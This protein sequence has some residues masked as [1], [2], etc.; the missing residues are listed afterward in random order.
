MGGGQYFDPRKRDWYVVAA[1]GPK[2]IILVLDR[3][4]ITS[5]RLNVLSGSGDTRLRAI[6]DAAKGVLST[7]SR[8]DF[9]S[10]VAFGDDVSVLSPKETTERATNETIF[11]L[12]E[13]IDSLTAQ[14]RA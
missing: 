6:K 1:T 14:G 5:A 10:V 13:R 7:L 11:D 9:V 2:D 8:N 4:S 3:S 12:K